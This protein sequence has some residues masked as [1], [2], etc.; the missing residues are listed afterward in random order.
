MGCWL[1]SGKT[2]EEGHDPAVWQAAE[3]PKYKCTRNLDGP[4]ICRVGPLF[5][6]RKVTFKIWL[7]G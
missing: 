2:C 6:S 7:S 3:V 4:Q 5:E 1:G